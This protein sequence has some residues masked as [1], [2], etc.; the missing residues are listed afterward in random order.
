VLV[1]T[2]DD[3]ADAVRSEFDVVAVA[4]EVAIGWPGMEVLPTTCVEDVRFV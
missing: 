2:E 4:E 1:L 3:A